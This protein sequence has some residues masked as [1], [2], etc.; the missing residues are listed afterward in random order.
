MNLVSN[1]AKTLFLNKNLS[2]SSSEEHNGN[3][4]ES[5]HVSL[6]QFDYIDLNDIDGQAG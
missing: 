2:D 5:E 3:D 6:Y 1:A 4:D